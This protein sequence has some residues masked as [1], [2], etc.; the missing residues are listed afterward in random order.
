M[1]KAE[2]EW[3]IRRYKY[4]QKAIRQRTDTYDVYIGKRKCR[5][6]ITEEVKKVCRIIE[7]VRKTLAEDWIKK[8]V[9]GILR[10]KSD[11]SLIIELPCEKGMYYDRKRKFIE[12]VYRCCIARDMVQYEELL[13]EGIA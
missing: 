4:I 13:R 6:V 7:D 5:I 2:I 10:G 12:Q 8:M 11:T 3:I 9:N 1:T